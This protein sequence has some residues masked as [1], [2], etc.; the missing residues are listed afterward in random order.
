MRGARVR[1]HAPARDHV[2]PRRAQLH[3]S[4]VLGNGR[5]EEEVPGAAGQ[6]REDRDLRPDRA[7]RGLR[8]RRDPDDRGAQGRP[9]RPQRR[10]DVDQPGRRRR[11]LPGDRLDRPGEE[12]AARPLGHVGLHRRARVQGLPVVHDQGEVGHPRRQHRRLLDAGRRGAGREPDRRGGRRLQGRDV[13]ARE[14]ALHRRLGRHRPHPRLP[15][16]LG[17]VRAGPQDLRRADRPAPA[18]EGDDRADGLR[19]RRLAALV[20]ARRP[21]EEPGPAQH[22]RDL[23][24]QVV[25]DRRERARRERR[26]ADPRRQRLLGRVP[27]G[28]LLPQLQGGRDLRG[29]PRGAQADAG[30]LRPWLPP[31]QAAP[32]RAASLQGLSPRP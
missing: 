11:P 16:R 19:L 8:R 14:R 30:R 5:P 23:A 24:R 29:Q 9:L 15:R 26:G 4:L 20:A 31:G 10:E 17:Q 1:G 3:D 32:G 21:H 2:G 6:G 22:A 27:G 18:G 13:R 28:P 7:E 25:R 12:E